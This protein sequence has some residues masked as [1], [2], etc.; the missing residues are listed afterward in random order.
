MSE[1]KAPKPARPGKN[2]RLT[3]KLCEHMTYSA[4]EAFKRLRT[5]VL[6]ACPE[7]EKKCHVIGVTSAQP[8]EGKST[9]AINL[10][11]SIAELGKRVLLVDGDMRRPS[12]HSK[13]NLDSSVGLSELLLGNDELTGAIVHYDSEKTHVPFDI[14]LG[15]S[16]PENPSELL[17]SERFTRM[18]SVLSSAYDYIV[19]DLPPCNAVIDAVSAAKQTD[20]MIVVIRENNCPKYVLSECMDQLKY[21]KVN[22]LGFVVNGSLEGAGKKYQYKYRYNNQYRYGY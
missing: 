14:L 7:T 16:V 8:T 13:L 4:R 22:V 20:G 2:P 10:S 11:Y 15:G 5:N 6:I 18:I 9:V 3:G 21:A 17:N 12:I 1:Q 19:L